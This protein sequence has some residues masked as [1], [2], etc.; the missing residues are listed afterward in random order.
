MTEQATNERALPEGADDVTRTGMP[1]G[2]ENYSREGRLKKKFYEAELARLQEE[3]RR[4][5]A[6]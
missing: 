6:V 3:D 4:E 1:A 2:E 5:K